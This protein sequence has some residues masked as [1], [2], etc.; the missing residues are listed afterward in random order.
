MKTLTLPRFALAALALTLAT[1]SAGAK[2]APQPKLYG[3]G[4]GSYVPQLLDRGNYRTI[5]YIKN[6]GTSAE[7]LQPCYNGAG[8]SAGFLTFLDLKP[9]RRRVS[10]QFH[11]RTR[12]GHHSRASLLRQQSFN[13]RD[14]VLISG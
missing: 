9:R 1:T 5:I 4:S 12:Q 7:S 3:I 11:R 6:F 8:L 13:L 2:I 14:V 10:A